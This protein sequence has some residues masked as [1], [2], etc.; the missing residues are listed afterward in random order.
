MPKL[1]KVE[2]KVE[3]CP[4]NGCGCKI[5]CRMTKPKEGSAFAPKLQWQNPDG[6]PHYNT[7]D[8]VNFTCTK[9]TTGETAKTSTTTVTEVKA[10]S[11]SSAGILD[12]IKNYDF[13]ELKSDAQQDAVINKARKIFEEKLLVT[14][15]AIEEFSAVGFD[16]VA[17][18]GQVE[19]ILNQ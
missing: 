1:E 5:V 12:F 3:T 7:K 6:T 8:G 11:T 10:S 19:G 17:S 2:G 18:I 4:A 15:V 16:N 9:P 14:K 13:K